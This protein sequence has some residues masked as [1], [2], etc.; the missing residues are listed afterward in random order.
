MSSFCNLNGQS[1]YTWSWT[2]NVL[3]MNSVSTQFMSSFRNLSWHFFITLM[4]TCSWKFIHHHSLHYGFCLEYH[5][6]LLGYF[7]KFWYQT[8]TTDT[9]FYFF[10][11]YFTKYYSKIWRL[12]SQYFAKKNLKWSPA[13]NLNVRNGRRW[14]QEDQFFIL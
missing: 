7:E 6:T 10:C 12:Q 11:V 14:S 5:R 3:T 2:N 13:K 9:K 8:D 1:F 4:A